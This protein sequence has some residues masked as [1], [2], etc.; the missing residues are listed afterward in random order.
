MSCDLVLAKVC[1]EKVGSGDET[2]PLYE[3]GTDL[4][5]FIRGFVA[6]DR[7]QY[8]SNTSDSIVVNR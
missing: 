4:Y 2:K 6:F 7:Q 3:R 8:D 1:G 5:R